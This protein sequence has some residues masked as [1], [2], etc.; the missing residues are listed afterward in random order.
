MTLYITRAIGWFWEKPWPNWKLIAA[1]E[2]T[3]VGGTLFAVYGILMPAVGW[4]LA[5]VVWAYAIVW[6][7]ILDAV[8]MAA[9][10]LL[11]N[12]HPQFSRASVES[13]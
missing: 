6:M 3:Q 11:R 2:A 8:K 9:H 1:L 5:G 4:A 10:H 13:S 12:V 7:F